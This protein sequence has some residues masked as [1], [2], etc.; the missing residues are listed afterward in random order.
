LGF[1]AWMMEDLLPSEDKATEIVKAVL[2]SGCN[3]IDNAERYANGKAE[4]LLGK[5]LKRLSVKRSNIVV[6]TKLF[7]GVDGGENDVGLSRKHIIEGL[8][9]S[10]ERLQ[11]S[12]VD[13]LFCHR[14]DSETPIEETVRAMNHVINQGKV[15]YWGTS[16]WSASEIE[17]AQAVA[18][19]LGLIGPTM[20]QPQYSMFNRNKM[21]RD[22]LSLF[23]S[24]GLGTTVWS[25]LAGGLLTGRYNELAT[26]SSA[27]VEGRFTSS[28]AMREFAKRPD[29]TELG[30]VETMVKKACELAP[31]AK[32][33]GCSQA[34]LALAWLISNPN[35]SC[36]LTSVS[37][38]EQV[39]ETYTAHKFVSKLT[40]E[41]KA[42]IEAIL[43]NK[44][45]LPMNLRGFSAALRHMDQAKK[46]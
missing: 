39:S 12:Y 23:H 27:V 22:Y 45:Q 34:Q 26:N 44:P 3:F 1:G 33:L 36:V 30:N 8:D 17:Q 25:P 43:G 6:S 41:V 28:S 15:F 10:L 13:L 19:R 9:A 7:F 16:E 21:E 20:E 18:D 24:I 37:R 38:I 5:V 32:R 46:V 11:M 35:V 42:E 14:P 31:I 29:L 2:D 40:P 4:I